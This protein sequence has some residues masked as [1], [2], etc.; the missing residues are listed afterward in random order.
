MPTIAKLLDAD[1]PTE[2]VIDG[3]DIWPLMV[4]EEG[5]T[6]PH[7]EFYCYYGRELHAVRDRRWK[8]H[9]PHPYRTLAGEPGG[10]GGYP[11][12]YSQAATGLELYDLQSDVGETKNVA[13]DHPEIVA[14]LSAAAERARTEFG[15]ILTQRQGNSVRPPGES[16]SRRPA[17]QPASAAASSSK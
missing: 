4:G 14:R 5:A 3:R 2:R 13:A 17:A 8:L 16:K 15:D 6:S 9:L 1:L 10:R 12:A 11:V 7:D